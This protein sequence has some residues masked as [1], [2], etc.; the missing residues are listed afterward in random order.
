MATI[1][2]ISLIIVALSSLHGLWRGFTQLALG[3][4]SWAVACVLAFRFHTVP[5]PWLGRF[6]HSPTGLQLASFALVLLFFLVAGYLL[7]ALIVRLVRATPLDGLDRTLGGL[8][9]LVRGMCVVVLLFM[10]G[11]WLLQPEDMEAIETNGRLTPYIRAAITYIH[12][13]LAEFDAKGVAPKRSTGHDA[14]L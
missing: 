2:A 7:A 4:L 10:T 12:P 9:G 8:F 14:T 3:L 11:Q 6:I 13:Y 1:D 5:V